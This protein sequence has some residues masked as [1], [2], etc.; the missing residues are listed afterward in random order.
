MSLTNEVGFGI[1]SR[2]EGNFDQI[3]CLLTVHIRT[4]KDAFFSSSFCYH[5]TSLCPFHPQFGYRRC[6]FSLK[7]L[8]L[9]DTRAIVPSKCGA[10]TI[11]YRRD[12]NESDQ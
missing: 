10:D 12:D 8:R 2:E 11:E 1:N 5:G 9:S 6:I 3:Q 7:V 4:F